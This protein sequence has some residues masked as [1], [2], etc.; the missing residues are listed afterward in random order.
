[1]ATIDSRAVIDAI[2]ANNGWSDPAYA[3]E[4]ED[5]PA[6]PPVVKIVEYTNMAGVSCWGVVFE[7]EASMKMIP[8]DGGPADLTYGD[9][10]EIPTEYVRN[11]RVIWRREV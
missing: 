11:P 1:M 8:I 6:E 9:R 4:S 2:I 10:Y 3:V 7:N 5:G